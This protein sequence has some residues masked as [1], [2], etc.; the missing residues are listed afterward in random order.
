LVLDRIH[1]RGEFLHQR[2][3]FFRPI[4]I[5]EL[6]LVAVSWVVGDDEQVGVEVLLVEI[7]YCPIYDAGEENFFLDQP[8]RRHVILI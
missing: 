6:H 1:R 3:P 2:R 8:E 5:E 4:G 7:A